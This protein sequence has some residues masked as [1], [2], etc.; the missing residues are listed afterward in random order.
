MAS[1]VIQCHDK[2]QPL[3]QNTVTWETE[4]HF[5]FF[6]LLL[7]LEVSYAFK[8]MGVSQTEIKNMRT[9]F[10]YPINSPEKMTIQIMLH[11]SV[12]FA[13]LIQF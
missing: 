5:V 7:K 6:F 2:R 8:C 13:Q 3:L 9:V 10:L 4:R 12:H 1:V 11:L